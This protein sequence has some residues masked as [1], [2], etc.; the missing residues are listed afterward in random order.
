GRGVGVESVHRMIHEVDKEKLALPFGR[1]TGGVG[2]GLGSSRGFGGAGILRRVAGVTRI[3]RR[4]TDAASD[5]RR[6]RVERC[7]EFGV[8]RV[9]LE[10]RPAVVCAAHQFVD[11]FEGTVPDIGEEETPRLALPGQPKRVAYAARPNRA[12]FSSRRRQKRVVFGDGSVGIQTQ[13]FS[14]QSV[15]S[16]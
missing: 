6:I 9:T 7:L 15:E 3:K 4:A 13:N 11:L 2:G 16:L 5:H 10:A 12:V 14:L 1:K 8:R